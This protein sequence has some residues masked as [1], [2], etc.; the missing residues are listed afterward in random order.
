MESGNLK[1]KN[2]ITDKSKYEIGKKSNQEE[3]QR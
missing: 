3:T 1:V 2:L